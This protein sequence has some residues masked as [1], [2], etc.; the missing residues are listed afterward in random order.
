M[1]RLT[2]PP[3]AEVASS[4]PHPAYPSAR[5]QGQFYVPATSRLTRRNVGAQ[6][7]PIFIDVNGAVHALSVVEEPPPPRKSAKI[8]ATDAAM[9]TMAFIG[10][11]TTRA[12]SAVRR[13]A[14]CT[15]RSICVG[16][17]IVL[18]YLFVTLKIA[19]M[20]LIVGYITMY[21]M[22]YI[23]SDALFDTVWGRACNNPNVSFICPSVP[24]PPP[25]I[26][27]LPIP[28]IPQLIQLQ[29]G[30]EGIVESSSGMTL[31]VDLKECEM[32]VRDL[33]TLV[34]VSDLGCKE[35][36]SG[37]LD[38]VTA[39]AKEIGLKLQRLG[40][41]V[42]GAVDSIV[43]M[44]EYVLRSL[45]TINQKLISVG[46]SQDSSFISRIAPFQSASALA[47]V[48]EQQKAELI[49]VFDRALAHMQTH[50]KQ[51][52]FETDATAFELDRLEMTLD[53]VYE[54]VMRE[55]RDIQSKEEMLSHIWDSL[56]DKSKAAGYRWQRGL[57]DSISRYRKDALN[58]V[59][60]TAVQLRQLSTN[61]DVLRER[62]AAP[63][64]VRAQCADE[65]DGGAGI[66]IEAYMWSVKEGVATLRDFRARGVQ[67]ENEVINR[68]VAAPPVDV[69][70]AY[71]TPQAEEAGA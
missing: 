2:V 12:A 49:R 54:I 66:P 9:A 31:A 53:T 33:N 35:S 26:T 30:F 18:R 17:P 15:F 61:L 70:T 14:N 39:Q 25:V 20:I 22:R 55:N 19:S 50:I 10:G 42:G 13:G 62:V 7:H 4:G 67:R 23:S 63:G 69:Q 1:T 40:G 5:V 64:L 41:R 59:T 28:D 46:V 65:S 71:L 27:P 44:D 56:I 48:V 57:L 11:A 36:L 16:A 47:V 45:G 24:A 43:A 52:I 51:L 21:T 29:T 58:R 60:A 3:P 8:V 38:S 34:K 68:M 32:A 37:Q 6:Q